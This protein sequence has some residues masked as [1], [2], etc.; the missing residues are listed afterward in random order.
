MTSSDHMTDAAVA[1]TR[2]KQSSKRIHQT[3]TMPPP[4]FWKLHL[5][6]PECIPEYSALITGKSW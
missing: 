3:P 4:D 6:D 2:H 5:E 1:R